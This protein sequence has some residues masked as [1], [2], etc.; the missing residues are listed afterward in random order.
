MQ[1][2][3]VSSSRDLDHFVRLPLSLYAGDP[4]FVPPLLMERKDFLDPKKNPFFRHAHH[5]LFLARQGGRVVGRIAAVEDQNYNSF[6]G[7]DY[8]N[9]GMYEAVD[10][11][12]VARGLFDAGMDW[13][14]RRGRT[15][16]MGPVS[17]SSN[18]EIGLLIDGFDDPPTIQVP[19]NP[20]YY[21]RHFEE[22]FG[23][24]K[25]KDLYAWWIDSESE[26]DPKIVRIAER[27]RQKEGLVVRPVRLRDLEAEARR[28]KE[29][30]NEAWE[31]NWGFVPFT[32]EEFDQVARDMKAFVNP[33]L[34][35]I[36]EAAGE[37]VAFA[38]A[39]PDVNEALIHVGGRLTSYGLPIGLAKLLYYSRKITRTRLMTLGV[40]ERFRKRGIDAV[41]YLELLY[42]CRK[43]GYRGADISWTLE[44]NALVNRAIET[45]G[46]KH[47]K[48]FRVYEA[49]VR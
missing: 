45:M 4:N 41:L 33:D 7:T 40:K 9:L 26:P 49:E 27:V 31:K 8:G 48:T 21:I 11:D 39:L 35:L 23:L 22:V 3:P 13:I 14:R 37:P 36:A 46:G 15:R 47:S 43:H 32:D 16:M 42:A 29:I 17:L 12:A 5:Q 6:H 24:E 34:L 10:D 25:S 19:Y 28:I 20:R 18:H 1:I 30:Y 2:A 38:M 44:D